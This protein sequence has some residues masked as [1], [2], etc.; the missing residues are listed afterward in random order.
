MLK[1]KLTDLSP[2][3]QASDAWR[4]DG[5]DATYCIVNNKGKLQF[6]KKVVNDYYCLL[7]TT[8]NLDSIEETNEVIC[9]VE[10][11]SGRH[12][13]FTPASWEENAPLI[14]RPYQLYIW[15]CYTLCTDYYKQTRGIEMLKFRETV[16]KLR[17]TFA[18]TDF[19]DNPEMI[20][21]ERVAI[22]QE[23]DGI[24]FSVGNLNYET[25]NPN[26]CGIYTGDNKFIHQFINRVSCEEELSGNW[27]DWVVC[28]MR[29][30][31]G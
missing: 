13:L 3:I 25:R 24:L 8:S 23:G 28:Y 12:C 4:E 15:D 31:D 5:A 20:N 17:D 22:P 30:K 18:V 9:Y 29:Y 19:V 10:W 26:H 6:S 7:K 16:D 11:P 2:L 27:K 1:I 21:W 14:G